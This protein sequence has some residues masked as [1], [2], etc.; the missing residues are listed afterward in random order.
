MV[1]SLA[2][3]RRVVRSGILRPATRRRR[4]SRTI[5][6]ATCAIFARHFQ[7][8]RAIGMRIEL[9]KMAFVSSADAFRAKNY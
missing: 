3:G 5:R 7:A 1:I 8:A 6:T 9:A 2:V 4:L